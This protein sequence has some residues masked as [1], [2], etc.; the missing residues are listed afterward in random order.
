MHAVNMVKWVNSATLSIGVIALAGCAS[1]VSQ[2]RYPVTIDSDQNE[3]TVIVKNKHGQEVHKGITPAF[4][5]LPAGAGYFSPARYT[6]H[7]EKEGYRSTTS[8]LSASLDGWYFG[9]LLFG[10]LIGFLIVDPA[11]GAMWKLDGHV[12]GRMEKECKTSIPPVNSK[13][14]SVTPGPVQK[15]GPSNQATVEK[16]KQLKDL[17]ESGVI[18]NEEY[19]AK[20]KELVEKL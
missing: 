4:V 18:T 5:T 2:S 15:I 17:K 6:M 7:F 8:Q 10:G 20:R 3:T 11:S 13:T 9:N 16:L 1:I 14:N 19:E 12:L